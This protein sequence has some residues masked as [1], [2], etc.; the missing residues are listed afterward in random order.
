MSGLRELAYDP[1]AFRESAEILSERGLKMVEF[2]QTAS[3]MSPASENLY[4]LVKEGRIVH[5]GDQVFKEQVLSA[6]AAPTDRSWRIS[7]RKSR[8]R[9]DG[10]IA[11]AMMA[12]RAMEEKS[13]PPRRKRSLKVF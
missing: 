3:R 8:Q 5:D 11:L 13:K 2:P 9:I 7:K 1:W 10:C 12:D 6:V 4:E